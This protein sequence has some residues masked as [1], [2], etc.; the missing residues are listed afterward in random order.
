MANTYA[1]LRRIPDDKLGWKPHVKSM[2]M[3]ELASHLALF[4]GWVVGTLERE[5]FDISPPD[6]ATQQALQLDSREQILQT[7]N[8][9]SVKAYA[10]L[11]SASDAHLHKMWTLL[12]G[13]KVIFSLSRIDVLL[14][15][16]LSHM[17][18]HRAQLGVYQPL[19][20]L[21]VPALY[22]PSADEGKF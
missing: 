10:A 16:A 2:T 4:P 21:P 1:A 7:F 20:D 6:G 11:R 9:D 8:R 18:H 15:I 5:S 12:R 17:I 19:N 14:R 22:G 3:R 13:G